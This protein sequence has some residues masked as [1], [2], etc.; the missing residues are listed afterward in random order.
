MLDATQIIL[1]MF[2][3]IVVTSIVNPIFLVPVVVMGVGF[4]FIRKVYLKTSKNI[5]RLEGIS[6]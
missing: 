2:G 3:A 1:V 6:M 5:K 4:L